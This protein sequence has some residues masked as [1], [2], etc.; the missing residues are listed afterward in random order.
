MGCSCVF[1]GLFWLVG[2]GLLDLVLLLVV[3]LVGCCFVFCVLTLIVGFCFEDSCF[4][5]TYCLRFMF[6]ILVWFSWTVFAVFVRL[7]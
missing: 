3:L 2:F 7:V 6:C 1:L 5:C 4:V